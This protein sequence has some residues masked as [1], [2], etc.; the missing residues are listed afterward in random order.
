MLHDALLDFQP[1]GAPLSLIAAAGAL[2]AASNVI[3]ILGSGVGTPPANI[4]GV[5]NALFGSDTGEGSNRPLIQ[6][7]VGTAFVTANGN[8]L[9][10]LIQGAPDTGAA[11]GYQPGAWQTYAA[12]PVLTAAQLTAG[13]DI[14]MDWPSAFPDNATPRYLRVAFQNAAGETF[15]AGSIAYVITTMARD[16]VANKYAQKNFSV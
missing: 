1:V 8:T 6:A 4:I 9:Q 3:D 13:Q 15:T 5:Q 16:D 10:M 12:S 2:V 7:V 11:G 14:R